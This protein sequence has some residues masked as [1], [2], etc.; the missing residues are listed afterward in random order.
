MPSTRPTLTSFSAG[1]LTP[2]L[3]GRTDVSVYYKGCSQLV[4]F[5]L[6][7]QGGL[8]RRTGTIF[9]AN[10]H[11]GQLDDDYDYMRRHRLIPFTVDE[12]N[13]YVLEATPHLNASLTSYVWRVFNDH[14]L[15]LSGGS[16]FEFEVG[17]SLSDIHNLQ[18]LQIQEVMY[19]VSR[20]NPS[21]KITY[22]GSDTAWTAS[23]VSWTGAFGTSLT[24]SSNYPGV[25]GFA[26]DRV[27]LGST[28]NHPN[29]IWGSKVAIGSLANYEA[30]TEGS[31][32]AL[33][34][35]YS[36]SLATDKVQKVSWITSHEEMVVG[37]NWGEVVITGTAEEG[38][39]PAKAFP[40]WRSSFGAAQIQAKRFQDAIVFVAKGAMQ[41]REY[42]WKDGW[43]SPE[44]TVHA[45]H[46]GGEFMKNSDGVAAANDDWNDG[47]RGFIDFDI[48]Q[49]PEPIIWTWRK[50]GKLA[51]LVY[52]KEGGVAGWS[53]MEFGGY[54]GAPSSS[55]EWF[56]DAHIGSACVIPNTKGEDELWLYAIRWTPDGY[57]SFVEYMAPGDYDNDEDGHFVDCGIDT[58]VS[59]KEYIGTFTAAVSSFTFQHQGN[60]LSLIAG[61]Y[62]RFEGISPESTWAN[63]NLA[64]YVIDSVATSVHTIA[65]VPPSGA[66][67]ADAVATE[68]LGQVMKVVGT[69]ASLGHLEGFTVDVNL[70]G[71][72][73]A[74]QVVSSATIS[75]PSYANRIHAGIPYTSKMRTMNLGVGSMQG[76]TGKIGQVVLRFWKSFGGKV[77]KSEDDTLVDILIKRVFGGTTYAEEDHFSGDY[78][79]QFPAGYSLDKYVYVQQDQPLPMHILAMVPDVYAS[80]KG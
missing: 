78:V 60:D 61:D 56:G 37:T 18:L 31:L 4:N 23:I 5:L 76:L 12:A 30:I 25:I 41:F 8:R 17:V 47:Q 36:Y 63:L 26:D 55:N 50:D 59:E 48:Q 33:A 1:E 15:V 22:G 65:S 80:H 3:A 77:G 74:S 27:I 73:A 52:D 72:A 69:T 67:T 32:A 20:N 70:D 19:L 64:V 29:R 35:G 28:I 40:H 21:H 68:L 79:V 16:A 7:R 54:P 71:M 11:T 6:M 75:L 9:A 34:D 42:F 58:I 45:D 13:A 51:A 57:R 66:V 24:T 38:V 2:K 62:V 43:R 46:M 39:T 49:N 53:R 44:L 14:A 10:G